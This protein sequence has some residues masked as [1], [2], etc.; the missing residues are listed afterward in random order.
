MMAH[1]L[2]IRKTSIAS[3]ALRLAAMALLRGQL[4]PTYLFV[5]MKQVS[6]CFGKNAIIVD[7]RVIL[8]F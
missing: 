8:I 4:S 6:V 5:G 2:A 7:Y 1:M 3:L